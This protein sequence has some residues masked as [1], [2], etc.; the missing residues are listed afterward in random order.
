MKESELLTALRLDFTREGNRLFRN[1]SGGAW[2]GR[3]ID[4]RM[5][6]RGRIVTL[7]G[8]RRVRSGLTVGAADLIGWRTITI[9]P[10]LVGLRFAVFA[11]VEAKTG[12]TPITEQ[13]RQFLD[14]VGDAG[15][16]AAVA[17]ELPEGGY[18]LQVVVP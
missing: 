15:G 18:D 3:V 8:A 4:E 11:A 2:H 9:T 12:R 6:D 16:Y 1:H 7:Q 5:S 10:A 14:A 17:R 13:Q